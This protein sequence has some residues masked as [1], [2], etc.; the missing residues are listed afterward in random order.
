[1]KNEKESNEVNLLDIL[2]DI[3]QAIVTIVKWFIGIIGK[4]FQLLYRNLLI[5]I[6]FVVL[7]LAVSQYFAR[8]ANRQ[9]EMGAIAELSGITA[10]DVKELGRQLKL[11]SHKIK[12]LSFAKKL[13]IPDSIAK[14]IVKIDFF[15]VIDYQKDS[16]P[17]V[18]DFQEN[19][20]L[21]DTINV[22]MNDR[23][24]IQVRMLGTEHAQIIENA[25]T[26][27][28]NTND[29]A[30]EQ[31]DAYRILLQQEIDIT[32]NEMIRLDSLAKKTYFE[33]KKQQ[34]KFDNNQLIVGNQYIQLF[35]GD[36]VSLQK[37][38]ATSV[39]KLAKAKNPVIIPSGFVVD[40]NPVNGRIKYGIIGM[41]IGLILALAIET[42]IENYRKWI[43]FLS[44]R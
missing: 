5:T 27:Y 7:G 30:Q 29:Y 28:L 44:K 9:Y 38:K 11:S 24:Y 40:P 1:M 15:D 14:K 10:S 12:T 8:V 18:I 42:V 4:T 31:I 35:W 3:W 6:V 21:N 36:M 34:L 41:L 22:R 16:I 13:D 2:L 19:H 23:I 43:D 37:I 32:D 26:Q 25:V 33:D 20:S 17:D 39:K